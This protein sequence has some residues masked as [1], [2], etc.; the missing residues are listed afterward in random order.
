MAPIPVVLEDE[1]TNVRVNVNLDADLPVAQ[2]IEALIALQRLPRG[3]YDNP[4][5]Y[6]LIRIYD[7]TPLRPDL[8]LTAQ[9]IRPNDE[10]ALAEHNIGPAVDTRVLIGL[11]ALGV[12]GIICVATVLI[13]T[14]I[15]A[16]GDTI[17]VTATPAVTLT[18]TQDA[19]AQTQTADVAL[20]PTDTIE[21]ET[22][23]ES[24]GAQRGCEDNMEFVADVTVPDD[25]EF[26]E[27]E[28]FSKTWRIKN[29][30]SCEWTSDYE[31]IFISGDQM[32]GPPSQVLGQTVAPGAQADITVSMTAPT[33]AGDY[34]G[35]WQLR[36][37]DGERFGD[38]PW[39]D[40]KVVGP[41][42]VPAT[43]NAAADPTQTET[44]NE[45]VTITAQASRQVPVIM[46]IF[47]DDA[48]E[49]ELAKHT[50]TNVQTCTYEFGG[51][52]ND[53]VGQVLYTAY[54][55]QSESSCGEDSNLGS[56]EGS[57]NIA[58]TITRPTQF[59]VVNTQINGKDIT[60]TVVWGS[61][62]EA[63]H[64]ELGYRFTGEDFVE[65]PDSD[66]TTA[67]FT[68]KGADVGT[69]PLILSVRACTNITCSEY[70]TTTVTTA[71]Y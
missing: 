40:I 1:V 37:S 49:K 30:G 38:T 29:I 5:Q 50:C 8:S 48:G 7:N 60:Y 6:E 71:P 14:L 35:Y 33:E 4:R 54:A 66:V 21:P 63:T 46:I 56:D 41:T 3:D 53:Y 44:A 36:N 47:T 16:Q 52:D 22:T 18:P 19:V 59:T 13:T 2:V 69:F 10:L 11:G 67:S 26:V 42:P 27:G 70:I 25:T 9:G 57:F 55:C 20:T 68:I 65:L 39:V 43:V 24:P 12:I 15:R 34:L 62:V 45:L 28:T 17:E 64:Y 31:W 58:D 23:D 32:S 61:V 51:N